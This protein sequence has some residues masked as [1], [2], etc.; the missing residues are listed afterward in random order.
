MLGATAGS[1]SATSRTS[2]RRYFLLRYGGG[3][4]EADAQRAARSLTV[5]MK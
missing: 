5:A 2:R 3:A 4:L 1:P